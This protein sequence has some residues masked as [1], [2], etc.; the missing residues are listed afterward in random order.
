MMGIGDRSR[1]KLPSKCRQ[2]NVG[3]IAGYAT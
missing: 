2:T 1:L 3:K